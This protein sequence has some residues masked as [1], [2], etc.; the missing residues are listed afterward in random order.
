MR[1][2]VSQLLKEPV[3]S[4]R[5]YQLSDR[6]NIME[7]GSSAVNGNARLVRTNRSIL[8]KGEFD[9]SVNLTCARCL[10]TFSYPLKVEFEEEYLPATD[11][12][13]FAPLPEEEEGEA[14]S[15]TIDNNCSID[16]TEAIRQYA[17]LAVPMKPLC[18]DDC[19]GL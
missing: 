4:Q 1:I 11:I 14:G 10:E 13:D 16:L 12:A 15:F 19:K 9:T 3:G 2:N 17:L 7:K 18:S 5:D 8:V 6:V